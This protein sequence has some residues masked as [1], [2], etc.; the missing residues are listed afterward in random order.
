MTRGLLSLAITSALIG[1]PPADSG[2][3]QRPTFRSTTDAVLVDVLVTRGSRPLEGL[4]AEDFAVR[5]AGT[6]QKP[7]LLSLESMPVDV[8]IALDVSGSVDGRRLEQLKIAARAAVDALRPMDRVRLLSFSDE[9]KVGTEWTHDR[10]PIFDAISAISAAGWT[11][12]VDATFTALSL[13]T[14]PGRRSLL[15][16]CT[17][18]FDTSSWLSPTDVLR[19]SEQSWMTVYGVSAGT[20]STPPRGSVDFRQHLAPVDMAPLPAAGQREQLISDP[21]SSRY[22]FLPVLVS[23]TGGE[24]LRAQGDDLRATFLDVLLRFSKRYLLSYAPTNSRA[25][26][27]PIEVRL[28]DRGLTVTAK[29]GYTR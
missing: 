12:L 24:V 20:R 26:W 22:L 6:L 9:I 14:E 13:P 16:L 8:S 15:L 10:S 7:M 23:D 5:D 21:G 25:G 11:S 3:Q 29:R 28:K 2:R 1:F 18:G 19:A 17:D 4:R 27:H